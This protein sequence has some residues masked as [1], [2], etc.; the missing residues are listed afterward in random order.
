MFKDPSNCQALVFTAWL[1]KIPAKS[2]DGR[3]NLN[4]V[5]NQNTVEQNITE[6]IRSLC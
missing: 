6:F 3:I 1:C 2:T 5:A 4:L